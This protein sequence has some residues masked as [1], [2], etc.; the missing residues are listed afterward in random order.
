MRRLIVAAA[1]VAIVILAGGF[2]AWRWAEARMLAGYTTY[3]SALRARGWAVTSG[4]PARGGWPLAIELTLP[5]V[6]VAATG[7]MAGVEFGGHVDRVRLRVDL[8]RPGALLVDCDGGQA[9][10][11]GGRVIPFSAERCAIT[12]PLDSG[13]PRG[14]AALDAAGLRFGGPAAGM[15]VGLL[16]AQAHAPAAAGDPTLALRISAEAIALPPPPAPQAAL[17]GHIASATA[18]IDVTG[19]WP[20]PGAPYAMASAWRDNGGALALRRIAIGW[21]PLGITGTATLALDKAMQPSGSANLRLVGTDEALAALVT[22]HAISATAAKAARAVLGLMARP[23]ADGAAAGVEVP[24]TLS[25]Q[26]VSLGPFP[27]TRLRA[28]DWP[29]APAGAIKAP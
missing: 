29:D 28:L 26:T 23:A 21:G 13:V 2:L 3:T 4:P 11:A 27:M 20:A 25:D 19:P 17:G 9:W 22:A 16:Q 6:E 7:P 15:T 12:V 1:L 8:L 18:E 14:A 10:H 5:D 24:L